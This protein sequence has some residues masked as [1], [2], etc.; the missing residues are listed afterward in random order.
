MKARL[1]L[2]LAVWG[3]GAGV[4]VEL[5][6]CG[7]KFLV[8]SRGTR[9]GKAP[10]AR[11]EA[12]ILVYANPTS[13][14]SNVFGELPVEKILVEAGYQPTLVTEAH[15]IERALEQGQWDLVLADLADSADLRGQLEGADAPMVVPVLY[16]PT[17]TVM[18]QAKKDYARVVKAPI[19][20]QRFLRTIDDAVALQAR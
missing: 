20:S 6:A 16:E 1:L 14:L 15:E 19:K 10:M 11:A 4:S 5:S 17:R 2:V 7:N 9:F 13:S 18:A 8:A 12:S 3:A